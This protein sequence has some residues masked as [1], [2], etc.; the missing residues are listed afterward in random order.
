MKTKIFSLL[1]LTMLLP[2]CACANSSYLPL[3]VQHETEKTMNYR[4]EVGSPRVMTESRGSGAFD[5]NDTP[6]QYLPL[7]ITA[8]VELK[9]YTPQKNRVTIDCRF[10]E[11]TPNE[12]AAYAKRTVTLQP[13]QVRIV[14]FSATTWWSSNLS[15]WCAMTN[16]DFVK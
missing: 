7:D 16:S 10:Y 1:A 4:V 15:A 12:P 8:W 11:R 2:I 3:S 5:Q 6:P 9:N 14:T 13:W